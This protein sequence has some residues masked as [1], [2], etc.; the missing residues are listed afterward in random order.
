MFKVKIA[1]I[2]ASLD[3]NKKTDRI[4]IQLLSKENNRL[5]L[6]TIELQSDLDIK[7][8]HKQYFKDCIGLDYDWIEHK[9]L[10]FE[11][12]ENTIVVYYCST[13]PI[14]TRINNDLFFISSNYGLDKTIIQKAIRYV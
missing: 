13:I 5:I 1:L 14:E 2:I 11:Q 6:P 9:L 10:D 12:E 4:E 7:N 3:F 8:Q